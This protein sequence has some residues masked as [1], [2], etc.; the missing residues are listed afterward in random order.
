MPVIKN[1]FYF[2]FFLLIIS[3]CDYTEKPNRS[4]DIWAD[5]EG[6]SHLKY[7]VGENETIG[8][9]INN[10]QYKVFDDKIGYT[11]K[12][13]SRDKRPSEETKGA[14]EP[15]KYDYH[16]ELEDPVG[17]ITLSLVFS[18]QTRSH[19]DVTTI[20]YDP[21]VSCTDEGSATNCC[22]TQEVSS[23]RE[24]GFCFISE[25]ALT[26]ARSIHF[27]N[28]MLEQSM[29]RY[30]Q[31]N[32]NSV[33]ATIKTYAKNEGFTLIN[34]YAVKDYYEVRFERENEMLVLE[35]KPIGEA[36]YTA[37]ARY[38]KNNPYSYKRESFNHSQVM[39]MDGAL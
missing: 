35:L 1:I 21:H 26:Q 34:T 25:L 12:N 22:N 39:L 27:D 37:L 36:F 31:I 38:P 24:A 5:L 8:D 17:T 29:S 28:A 14:L 11:I 32:V 10:L 4:N 3:S 33:L 7:K 20:L 30:P 13:L 6:F 19:K 23:A 9:M 16:I 18:I 15:F 2:I